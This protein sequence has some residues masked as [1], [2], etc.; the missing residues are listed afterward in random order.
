MLPKKVLP[1]IDFVLTYHFVSCRMLFL[2]IFLPAEL[3]LIIFSL[4]QRA[5]IYYRYQKQAIRLLLN[6]QF[7]CYLI[8]NYY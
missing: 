1:V 3:S 8:K 4:E 7:V 2:K 5:Q 6:K